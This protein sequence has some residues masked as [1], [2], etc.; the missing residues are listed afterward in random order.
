MPAA[1]SVAVADAGSWTCADKDAAAGA[2]TSDADTFVGMADTAQ[3]AAVET[4]H[5]MMVAW[6][7]DGSR[8]CLT[9]ISF[10]WTVLQTDLVQELEQMR[11]AEESLSCP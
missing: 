4:A 5:T 9:L 11:A 2:L 3:T 8:P 7:A 10:G 1:A 6:V